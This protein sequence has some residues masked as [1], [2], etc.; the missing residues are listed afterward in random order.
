[1]VLHE[2]LDKQ[3]GSLFVLHWWYGQEAQPSV[4]VLAVHM[5]IQAADLDLD[6]PVIQV[7]FR[8]DD[9]S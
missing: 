4:E 6:R 1:M 5:E 7:E 2:L 9:K 3:V 8:W